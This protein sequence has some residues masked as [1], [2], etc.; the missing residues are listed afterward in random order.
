MCYRQYSV[1]FDGLCVDTRVL[2]RR[3]Q[4]SIPR[5]VCKLSPRGKL[6]SSLHHSW[7]GVKGGFLFVRVTVMAP[8]FDY[9]SVFSVKK[10]SV[11]VIVL[12]LC[13][14]SVQVFKA[15]SC[16]EHQKCRI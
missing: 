12:K 11:V 8:Y 9:R 2:E 3:N 6:E 1:G 13:T 4:A 5:A 16:K 7:S 15:R 14:C 10:E